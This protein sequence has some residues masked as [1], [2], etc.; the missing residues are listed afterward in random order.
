MPKYFETMRIYNLKFLQL[1]QW[2][3]HNTR[4]FFQSI[5][6]PGRKIAFMVCD[7][8]MRSKYNIARSCFLKDLAGYKYYYGG[9]MISYILL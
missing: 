1:L 8:Y 6:D 4:E 5:S 7:L 3:I 2:F 9:L